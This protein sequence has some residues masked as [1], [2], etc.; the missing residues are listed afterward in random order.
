ML[1]LLGNPIIDDRKLTAE[2]MRERKRALRRKANAPKGYYK[3]PGSG[4]QGETCGSC[5]HAC[6]HRGAS[7]NY[8]KCDRVRPTHGPGTDIRLKAAACSGWEAKAVTGEVRAQ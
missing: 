6:C 2:D 4:P 1:D 7:K 5:G 3:S 8:W